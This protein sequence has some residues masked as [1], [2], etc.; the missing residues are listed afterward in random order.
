MNRVS[1]E[2]IHKLNEVPGPTLIIVHVGRNAI[3]S[4]IVVLIEVISIKSG[5][6]VFNEDSGQNRI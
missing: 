5:M 2:I 3:R 1:S 4:A 6:Y